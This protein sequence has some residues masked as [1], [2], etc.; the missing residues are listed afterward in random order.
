MR[1]IDRRRNIWPHCPPTACTVSLMTRPISRFSTTKPTPPQPARQSTTSWR[2]YGARNHSA[3][4][5]PVSMN[6][7]GQRRPIK[8]HQEDE[9]D[10][11]V[12]AASEV[13]SSP[14][15][16]VSLPHIAA[17]AGISPRDPLIRQDWVCELA[18]RGRPAAGHHDNVWLRDRA[19]L[20]RGRARGR[21]S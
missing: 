11:V 2:R 9:P 17:A 8:A 18:Q 20:S 7:D 4:A 5:D 21:W 13:A 1:N 3:R 15:F 12:T 16:V 10:A 14:T 6:D 19:A